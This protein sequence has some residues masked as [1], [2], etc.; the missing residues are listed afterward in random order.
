MSYYENKLASLR[1]MFGTNDIALSEGYLAVA[2][3][4]YPIIGDVIVLLDASQ[5]TEV[6]RQSLSALPSHKLD[7]IAPHSRAVQSSF[8]DQWTQYSDILEEHRAEFELYF[9]LID[10]GSL[11]DQKVCDLGCGTGRWSFFLQEYCD[12]L[13]LVD[14]SD[15]IFVARQ[16]L[17]GNQKTLF[18]MCDIKRLPFS[19]DFCDFLFSLGV[20]HHLPT[21]ALDE[22]KA[23]RKYAKRHLVYL[24]YALDNRP[25]HFRWLYSGMDLGRRFVSSLR[26]ARVRQ[27]IVWVITLFV[28]LPCIVLGKLLRPIGLEKQV[29]LYEFYN[30]KSILRIRQDVHD[31]FCTPIEH[32]YTRDQIMKLSGT[33][34]NVMVSSKIPYWHFLCTR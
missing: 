28:Y 11:K 3:V 14:F 13:I 21:D 27:A 23:L 4:T 7:N 16:N 32:R 33:Y 31:R 22:V 2:G 25:F 1:R 30:K 12:E 17:A 15:A 5:Y 24:Y 18:F 26:N 19:D 20:L 10:V 6:V 9:D 8:G 34:A 29:P